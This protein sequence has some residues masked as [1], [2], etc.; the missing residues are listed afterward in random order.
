[1]NNKLELK[2]IN[3]R[4]ELYKRLV[5]RSYTGFDTKFL[6]MNMLAADS[7]RRTRLLAEVG[8]QEEF[9]GVCNA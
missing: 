5:A 3:R 2:R 1:M 9:E 4:I 6:A 8:A 7:R